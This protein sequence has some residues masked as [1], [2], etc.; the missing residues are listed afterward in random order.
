MADALPCAVPGFARRCQL[1]SLPRPFPQPARYCLS[2]TATGLKPELAPSSQQKV[3]SALLQMLRDAAGK[4]GTLGSVQWPLV[5]PQVQALLEDDDPSLLAGFLLERASRQHKA[6]QSIETKPR[7]SAKSG[8]KP[9]R[10]PAIKPAGQAAAKAAP[11]TPPKP[12][13][14]RTTSPARRQAS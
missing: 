13:I 12:V 2:F 8:S 10:K 1:V 6:G 4:G 3:R 11:G 9:T 5:T 7:A 14:K